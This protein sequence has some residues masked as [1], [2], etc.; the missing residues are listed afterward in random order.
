MEKPNQQARDKSLDDLHKKLENTKNRVLEANEHIDQMGEGAKKIALSIDGATWELNA[1]MKQLFLC[2][3]HDMHEYDLLVPTLMQHLKNMAHI[4]ETR[5][6]R[7]K[8]SEKH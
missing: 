5:F 7:L 2:A 8:D 6:G 4:A 1:C 3:T